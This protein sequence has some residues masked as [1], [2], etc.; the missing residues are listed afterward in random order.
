MLQGWIALTGTPG[1]GK[2]TVANE[3]RLRSQR[4]VNL[5][6][7]AHDFNLTEGLDPQRLS[8]VVDPAKIA[9]LLRSMLQAGERVLLDGHWSHD[10]DD[11]EAAIV[12]RLRPRDLEERLRRRG[13]PEAKVRENVEA[14]AIDVILQ[15][16]V[17][18]FGRRGTFE[19]DTTGKTPQQVGNAIIRCFRARPSE[20]KYFEVGQVD[21]ADD[22]LA[23]F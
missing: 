21:W 7:V 14:E 8:A 1:V 2:T 4:T 13:W 11:V 18:R 17:A 19:I 22:I 3:L 12:L 16:A 23:W 5:A 9:P 10:V 6:Q 20:R 15:E